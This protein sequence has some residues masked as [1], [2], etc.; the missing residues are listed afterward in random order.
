MTC[1][2]SSLAAKSLLISTGMRCIFSAGCQMSDCAGTSIA[3]LLLPGLC[4]LDCRCSVEPR[5]LI[6]MHGL[7]VVKTLVRRGFR[8]DEALPG[9]IEILTIIVTDYVKLEMY[10]QQPELLNQT[11][12]GQSRIAS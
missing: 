9:L 8:L 7:E 1:H 5:L 2:A 4:M 10:H 6:V 12:V 3:I 11:T